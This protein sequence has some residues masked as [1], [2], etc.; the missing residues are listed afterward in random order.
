LIMT[1][2]I[3]QIIAIPGAYFF[4]WMAKKRGNINTLI[5]AN[6]I[7]IGICIGAFYTYT[8]V[9]F[10]ILAAVVGWVMGGVQALCRAPVTRLLPREKDIS[11]YFSF[12]DATEKFAIVFG[13][14]IYGTIEE[15]TGDM[16]NSVLSLMV[17]FILAGL[18]LWRITRVPQEKMISAPNV[19]E[20]NE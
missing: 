9:Q 4:A 12:Y 8:N 19:V 13:T 20:E 18:A 3:I 11:S 17:F 6:F 15:I 5:I 16:R 14:M 7:W 2:M 1:V 10:Y